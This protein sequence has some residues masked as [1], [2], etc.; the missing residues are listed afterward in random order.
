[1][2]LYAVSSDCCTCAQTDKANAKISQDSNL[3]DYLMTYMIRAKGNKILLVSVRTTSSDKRLQMRLTI[4]HQASRLLR[5]VIQLQVALGGLVVLP[6]PAY[7]HVKWFAPYDVASAP[8]QLAAVL[9]WPFAELLVLS[10]V[11]FWCGAALETTKIGVAISRAMDSVFAP[12]RPRTD[13]LVRGGTA[14][15]FTAI[16]ALGDIILTPELATSFLATQWLQAAIAIGVFWQPTMALSGL[17]I[18]ALFAQGIWSYGL[19]H[20]MDYPIFLGAAGYLI[21]RGL[22]LQSLRGVRPLD[23]VLWGS[24]ITLMW[25]S[26][27]KWAYPNWSYPVLAAHPNLTDGLDPKFFMLAAGLVEFSLAFA[28]LWTPMVRRVAAILLVSMFVSAVLEFGKIDA[29][30]HLLIIV[31]LLAIAADDQA[32]CRSKPSFAPLWYSVALATTLIAYYV[33]HVL[34]YFTPVI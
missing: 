3:S 28:L 17:G 5:G 13:S 34:I 14:M 29:I 25:A 21:M 11:L 26:V 32:S 19:F 22:G 8:K 20:M 18:V 23:V 2:A 27:E 24:A 9:N 6:M 31:L 12:L 1:M 15:F 16:F 10:I 7:A 33:G 4:N 30:G